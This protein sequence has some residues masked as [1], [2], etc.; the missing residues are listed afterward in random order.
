M[1]ID[2]NESYTFDDFLLVPQYTTIHSR[3]DV[4]TDT[5]LCKGIG[6]K[7]PI[8]ASNMDTITESQMVIA[9]HKSGGRGILHR[10]MNNDKMIQECMHIKQN[11]VDKITISIGV[12][13]NW[14][15]NLYIIMQHFPDFIDSVC[16][17]IA[18]GDC[19]RVL[20]AIKYIKQNFVVKIIAG[21]VATSEATKRL[22][23]AGADAVKCGIGP[24]SMCSTRIVTGCGV[25]Q[26]T[27]IFECVKSA[28]EYGVPVIADG[29]I[30]NS[31]DIVK[32]LAAG[33]DSVMVGNLLSGTDETPGDV[34][35]I[36]HTGYLYGK[37]IG[38]QLAKEYRGMASKDA[39]VD[40]KG[41]VPEGIAPEGERTIVLMKG[42]VADVINNLLGGIR[43]GMTYN[44]SRTISELQ[45]NAK[46]RRISQ[47][48]R[49]ENIPH[50][51]K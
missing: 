10:F 8:I 32:S 46:F 43:S 34:I 42:P 7:I 40:W 25:P 3:H 39:M 1:E 28:D 49:D 11:G 14:K 27:A 37:P 13:N 16:I 20:D 19:D 35:T 44:N 15:E 36:N 41:Q 21:N 47:S 26:L 4:H 30:R 5:V 33:A 6:M 50:G 2:N 38:G 29:G 17:D 23:D 51:I 48:T 22:C 9:M 18:H 24:G 45:I 31:A 12:A